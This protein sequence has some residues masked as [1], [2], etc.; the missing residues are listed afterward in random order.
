MYMSGIKDVPEAILFG[1]PAQLIHL[2]LVMHESGVRGQ[3][4]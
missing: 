1:Q 3:G 4:S 2:L